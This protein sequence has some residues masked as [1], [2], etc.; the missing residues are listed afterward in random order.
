MRFLSQT[1][2]GGV[3]QPMIPSHPPN[4]GPGANP[5]SKRKS[6]EDGDGVLR[7]A[8][9]AKQEVSSFLFVLYQGVLTEVWLAVQ[10]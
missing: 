7:N 8:K 4:T 10:S 9:K 6:P 3:E 2:G 1:I 5:A